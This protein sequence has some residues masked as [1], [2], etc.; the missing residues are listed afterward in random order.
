M[1]VLMRHAET[2]WISAHRPQGHSDV[3]LNAT[4]LRQA[5]ASEELARED[6]DAI[7]SSPLKRAAE[8]A[9]IVGF[10]A[11]ITTVPT[12]VQEV[13]PQIAKVKEIRRAADANAAAL[14]GA[15][16]K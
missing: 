14:G 11:G 12:F 15:A 7:V 13:A 2:S 5:V 3:P 8:T 6:W 10:G 4:R 16:S 9:Q 1:L